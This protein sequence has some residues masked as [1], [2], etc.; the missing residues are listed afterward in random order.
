MTKT[1][2]IKSGIMGFAH[3]SIIPFLLI[4]ISKDIMVGLAYYMLVILAYETIAEHRTV[5]RIIFYSQALLIFGLFT[6]MYVAIALYG[7]I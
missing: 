7:G 3:G 6:F 2:K 5:G 4:F 1:Q